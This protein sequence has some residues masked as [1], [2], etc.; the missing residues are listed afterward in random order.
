M[1]DIQP[2]SPASAEP[3]N[4]TP[5]L[6]AEPIKPEVPVQPQLLDQKPSAQAT[7]ATGPAPSPT[8]E[9]Q[10]T[11]TETIAALDVMPPIE[12]LYTFGLTEA[13]RDRLIAQAIIF[14]KYLREHM[15]RN[16]HNL[17][18][19]DI[20]DIGCGEG[21]VTRA[22][23]QIYPS[24]RIVGI[25]KD[26]KAIDKA[27]LDM[28]RFPV[29]TPIE[30][31]VADLTESLPEGPFDVIYTSLTLMYIKDVDKALTLMFN[32]LRP[33]GYI[34]IKESH[35]AWFTYIKDNAVFT[36]YASLAATAFIRAGMTMFIGPEL[37]QTL[38]KLGFT[39]VQYLEER[40]PIRPDTMEG[41]IVTS[42]VLGVIYNLRKLITRFEEIPEEELLKMHAQLSAKAD[43]LYGQWIFSNV[44]AQRPVE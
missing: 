17:A 36:R 14:S 27:K 3:N 13:D 12:N 4:P 22:I 40:H 39:N 42:I 23:G 28:T 41:R 19:K 10:S 8:A 33:G 32:T 38:S 34:W 20:L 31:K 15:K 44:I 7:S 1:S 9:S 21:Q 2:T 30:F 26:P 5:T 43:S 16:L 24:A 37:P 6:P 35:P 29:K 11:T 25:D 18:V